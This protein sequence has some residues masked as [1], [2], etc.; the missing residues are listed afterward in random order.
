[1]SG[2]WLTPKSIVFRLTYLPEFSKPCESFFKCHMLRWQRASSEPYRQDSPDNIIN[3]VIS[4]A[5]LEEGT[6]LGVLT[7]AWQ[8]LALAFLSCL[9]VWAKWCNAQ[10]LGHSL[11]HRKKKWFGFEDKKDDWR[12]TGTNLNQGK[13][14]TML[15]RPSYFTPPFSTPV[16]LKNCLWV[17]G[18]WLC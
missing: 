14:K 6:D 8:A 4:K 10:V 7:R 2:L 12:K 1:M 16:L 9:G 11:Y 17:Q 18:T 15:F 5:G 3:T 13:K